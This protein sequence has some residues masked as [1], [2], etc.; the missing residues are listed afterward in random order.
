MPPLLRDATAWPTTRQW[1]D[2][3]DGQYGAPLSFVITL[4]RPCTMYVCVESAHGGEDD[5]GLPSALSGG[6]SGFASAGVSVAHEYD[7]LT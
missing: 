5:C 1:I 4:R 2:P 7:H 6:P 3:D